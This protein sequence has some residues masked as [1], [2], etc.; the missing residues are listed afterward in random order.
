MLGASLKIKI[1]K[2]TI[3]LVWFFGIS[4]KFSTLLVMFLFLFLFLSFDDNQVTLNFV[5]FL[6]QSLLFP[7]HSFYQKSNFLFLVFTFSVCSDCSRGREEF[8]RSENISCR[9]TS[10]TLRHNPVIIIIIVNLNIDNELIKNKNLFT[11]FRIIRI[12]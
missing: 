3:N 5:L 10:S 1:F 7:F 9:S 2:I 12:V 11:V 4:S 8:S 6:W